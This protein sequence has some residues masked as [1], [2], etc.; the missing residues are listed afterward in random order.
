MARKLLYIISFI[1]LSISEGWSQQD[2][3]RYYHWSLGISSGDI[4]HELFNG[5][6][7]IRVMLL[8]Y[9]NMRDRIMPFS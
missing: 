1:I 4:L 8:L 7:Q 2:S 5:R 3:T 9:L 6:I